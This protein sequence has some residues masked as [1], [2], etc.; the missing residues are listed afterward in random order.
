MILS[1]LG[2][3]ENGGGAIWWIPPT[4]T[5]PSKGRQFPPFSREIV[6]K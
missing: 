3:M 2:G 5:P 6:T 4:S 1:L